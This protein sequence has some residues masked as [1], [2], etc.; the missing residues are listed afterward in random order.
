MN[1]IYVYICV[2]INQS[3]KARML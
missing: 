2:V 1:S 3:V